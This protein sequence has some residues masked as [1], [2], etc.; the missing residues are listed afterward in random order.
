MFFYAAKPFDKY[1]P[2][3][4]AVLSVFFFSCTAIK[5]YPANK[6]FVFEANIKIEAKLK[7]EEKK[8]L[9][10]QLTQQLHDSIGVRKQKKLIFWQE[11]KNPPVYDSANAEKSKEFMNA[12]LNSLG[13][14]R[15][16]ITYDTVVHIVQK[17]QY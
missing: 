12:L 2:I 8:Q 17:D 15:D 14:Y 13:Y 6:P 1:Y 10:Q 16:S 7:T 5:N 3:L 9:V 11:L 4:F